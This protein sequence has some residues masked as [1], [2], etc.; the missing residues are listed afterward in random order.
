MYQLI[1]EMSVNA[2]ML[3][4]R[5]LY[6]YNL[7]FK[8]KQK[9]LYTFTKQTKKKR[10]KLATLFN[11]FHVSYNA[12]SVLLTETGKCCKKAIFKKMTLLQS[13]VQINIMCALH[14]HRIH[15]CHI[16]FQVQQYRSTMEDNPSA[17]KASQKQ[18]LASV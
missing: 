7:P 10:H 12:P 17:S 3:N 11:S 6:I 13:T 4:N 8:T 5:N 9:S 15:I 16:L 14:L 1:R 2:Y 18:S